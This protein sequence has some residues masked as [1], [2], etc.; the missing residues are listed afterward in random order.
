M[1]IATAT[2]KWNNNDVR[3]V[4]IDGHDFTQIVPALASV[5]ESGN[6]SQPTKIMAWTVKGKGVHFTEGNQEWHSKV[7]TKEE[8]QTIAAKL[9]VKEALA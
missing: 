2:V 6:S 1:K 3:V 9:G 7:A 4:E 8:L 5:K